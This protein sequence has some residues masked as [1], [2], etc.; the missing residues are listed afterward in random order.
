MRAGYGMQDAGCRITGYRDI[1]KD[2]IVIPI[3][4]CKTTRFHEIDTTLFLFRKK[5]TC[6]KRKTATKF[7]RGNGF[8]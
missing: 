7:F 5:K 2:I 3:I 1:E 8:L 4:N 6:A